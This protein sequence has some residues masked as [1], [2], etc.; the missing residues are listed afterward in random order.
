M[1][2]KLSSLNFLGFERLQIVEKE[3]MDR[4]DELTDKKTKLEKECP[5]TQ[6][7]LDTHS[8]TQNILSSNKWGLVSKN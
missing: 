3:L 6:T 2:P 4:V 7:W 5:S 1:I 8:L